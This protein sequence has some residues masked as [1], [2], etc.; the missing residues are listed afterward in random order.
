[1]KE[2]TSSRKAASSGDNDSSIERSLP[3]LAEGADFQLKRPGALRLLVELPIGLCHGGR[4]HQEVGI[5]E[6]IGTECLDAALPHPFGI[7][8]GVDDEMRDVDVLRP[9]LARHRLRYCA[10]AKLGA[11]EG[12]IAAA[13][14]QGRRSTGAEDVAAAARHSRRRGLA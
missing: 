5:V 1:M 11:G 10:E 8:A 13:A 3:L 9:Q 2:R 7:D 6:R 14:A 4:W 12:G